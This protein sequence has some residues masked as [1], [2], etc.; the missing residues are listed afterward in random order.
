MKIAQRLY[1][2]VELGEQGAT[3]LI[4][5]M[6][7]DS[8]RVSDR[9]LSMVRGHIVE[10]YGKEY[11]PDQRELLSLRQVRRRMRTRRFARPRWNAIPN[12]WRAIWPRMSWRSTR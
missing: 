3:G 12:R 5:Y 2:G 8:P 1:E 11:L 9:R 10:R 4:T 7:T 6:R